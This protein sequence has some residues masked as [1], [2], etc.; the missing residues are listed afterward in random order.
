MTVAELQ[1]WLRTVERTLGMW[2]LQRTFPEVCALVTGVT[3]ADFPDFGST[4]HDWLFERTDSDR[5][6][7]A[8]PSL[9][10]LNVVPGQA[11]AW[12][13]ASDQEHEALNAAFFKFLD[14][15]LDGLDAPPEAA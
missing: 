1:E 5:Q 3:R 13:E 14:E 10:S 6:E 2:T 9:V 8:W 4:F 7:L 12:R 11:T 15:F